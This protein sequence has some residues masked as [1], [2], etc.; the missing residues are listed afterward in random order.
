VLERSLELELELTLSMHY[1][2]LVV[3]MNGVGDYS[4]ELLGVVPVEPPDAATAHE[5]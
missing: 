4:F 1:A 2:L 5:V 3:V